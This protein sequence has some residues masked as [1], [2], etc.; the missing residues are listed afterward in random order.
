MKDRRWQDVAMLVLGLWL[1]VSPFVLQYPDTL[2]IAALNSYVFGF[3]VMLFAAIALIKPQM[4]E[5]WTNLVLGIWLIV[6][7]VVLGFKTET[8]ATA[9]HLLIGLLIVI[10]ALSVMVPRY[11]RKAT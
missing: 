6:A 1:I 3:G 7:P 4:W 8:D 9:N 11:T 10:D 5:E 2:G